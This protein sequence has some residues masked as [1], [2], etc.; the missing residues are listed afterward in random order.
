M[1]LKEKQVNI[2][3]TGYEGI[4]LFFAEILCCAG[5]KILLLD[6][7]KEHSMKEYFPR[8]EGLDPAENIVDY[9]GIGYAVVSDPKITIK[10]GNS[11]SDHNIGD[12]DYDIYFKLFD[13]CGLC[14]E[15]ISILT[16]DKTAVQSVSEI[17]NYGSAEDNKPLT[18][19]T[20]DEKAGNIAALEHAAPDPESILIINDYTGTIKRRI[21]NTAYELGIAKVYVMPLNVRDRKLEILA[22]YNDR[23]KFT[24]LSR[25]RKEVLT[26]LA[27]LIIPELSEKE[28]RK[29]YRIAER[30]GRK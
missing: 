8:V 12:G 22:G 10:Q 9:G 3:G 18:I 30:G 5:K 23:F 6:H 27:G 15:N 2:V 17:K 11:T 28:I 20:T 24:G 19:Y 13:L 16:L 4:M 29:A 21:E 25:E 14:H 26:E 7:T 1:G